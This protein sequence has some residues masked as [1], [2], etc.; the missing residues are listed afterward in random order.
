MSP[1]ATIPS[2]LL[3]KDWKK[4]FG[5]TP[6]NSCERWTGASLRVGR[7]ELAALVGPDGAGKTTL[8][9]VA[10][11]LMTADKGELKGAGH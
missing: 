6:E 3:G 8:I 9:R 7:G 2:V 1:D 5:E 4:P 11:G 10:C